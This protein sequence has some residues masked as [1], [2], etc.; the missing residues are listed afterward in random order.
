MIIGKSYEEEK[1]GRRNEME[2]LIKNWSVVLGVREKQVKKR[3][4]HLA[5][6]CGC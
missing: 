2:E 4:T 6:R 5:A 1:K 3:S